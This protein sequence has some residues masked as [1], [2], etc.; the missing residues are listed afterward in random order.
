[1]YLYALLPSLK[2]PCADA[3]QLGCGRSTG[4]VARGPSQERHRFGDRGA[5][6]GYADL[7][8][9]PCHD[10]TFSRLDMPDVFVTILSC[11]RRWEGRRG[12]C[13]RGQES[14]GEGR[15][16]GGEG[17]GGRRRDRPKTPS[18]RRRPGRSSRTCASAAATNTAILLPASGTS[19]QHHNAAHTRVCRPGNHCFLCK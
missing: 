4:L 13:R 2:V 10:H 15:G 17:G 16:V 9:P 14:G 6:R 18:A 11:W 1:M 19:T 5:M 3:F 7:V 12:A 8:P